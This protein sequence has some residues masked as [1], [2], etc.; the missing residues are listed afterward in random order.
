M[1]TPCSG[2]SRRRGLAACLLLGC[3]LA[4]EYARADLTDGLIA[5]WS[6]DDCTA[7]DSSGNGLNGT[8]FG[9]PACILGRLGDALNFDVTS[10]RN[11]VSIYK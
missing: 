11:F 10:S 6:F 5:R 2:S 9:N 7:A 8:V 1:T 4:S 3:I